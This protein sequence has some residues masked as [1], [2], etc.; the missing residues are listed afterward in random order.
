MK[1]NVWDTSDITLVPV[2]LILD[3]KIKISK[4]MQEMGL[5]MN[6][7]GDWFESPISS[8]HKLNFCEYEFF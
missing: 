8:G 5:Y 7:N 6:M 1:K 4:P 3:L 2:T